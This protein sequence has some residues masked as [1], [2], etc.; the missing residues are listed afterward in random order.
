[1]LFRLYRSKTVKIESLI[2]L[3][4]QSL[5][6]PMATVEKSVLVYFTAEQMFSLVRN[7]EDYPHFLPWCGGSKVESLSEQQEQATVEIAFKG[8]RQS[9]TTLNTAEPHRAI[10]MRLVDGPFKSLQGEW[11]FLELTPEASKVM[12]TM[13]YEFSSKMLEQLVGPVFHSIANSF[14]DSFIK[15]AEALSSKGLL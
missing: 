8:V 12:F 10:H 13:D 5:F 7:V 14:V 6:E 4:G 9:F 1:M 3:T 2:L 11:T 15:R